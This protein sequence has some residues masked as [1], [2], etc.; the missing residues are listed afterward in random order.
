MKIS[1]IYSSVQGEGPR[2]GT[3]TVFIRT[4]GCN[5]RC[6]GWGTYEHTLAGDLIQID[7]PG[8]R[9]S[10]KRFVGCDS[11][12][13]VYPEFHK[14]WDT[15][16]IQEVVEGVYAFGNI[17]NVCLTGGEPL[18]QK[19]EEI[20]FLLDALLL[21]N[22][23]V[24]LFTNGSRSLRHHWGFI[25]L[26]QVAVVMDYK[27]PGSGE[28]GSFDISNLQ[29]LNPKKDWLKFVCKNKDDVAAA[30]KEIEDHNLQHFQM[31]F[32][33]VWGGELTT[34]ELLEM[35]IWNYPNMRLNVQLHKYLWDPNERRR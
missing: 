11:I 19:N 34:A 4:G 29:Y 3:P 15:M 30:V 17:R 18:I 25:G 27:L 35:P 5:L 23:T 22:Y 26:S 33:V 10:G 6:P 20:N 7:S 12:F 32:G 31:Y 14:S 21:R 28:F 16:S 13:A 8:S 2:V 24:D 9:H 1:E